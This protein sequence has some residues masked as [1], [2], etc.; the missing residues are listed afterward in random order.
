M[1]ILIVDDNE[2]YRKLLTAIFVDKGWEAIDAPEGSKG[3]EL[4]REHFPDVILSDIMMPHM[5]GF[6]FLRAVRTSAF[7]DILFIFYTSTYTK[8]NHQEFALSLGADAY[9]TKPLN[10]EDIVHVLMDI[11]DGKELRPKQRDLPN[12][13]EFLRLHSLFI[14]EKLMEKA[15]ELEKESVEHRKAEKELLQL[16]ERDR[17]RQSFVT[18]GKTTVSPLAP[19]NVLSSLDIADDIYLP[20]NRIDTYCELLTRD[21]T[22]SGSE[23]AALV[24]QMCASTRKLRNLVGEMG[25]NLY[26]P[27]S[28]V[29]APIRRIQIMIDVLKKDHGNLDSSIGAVL[30]EVEL[31]LRQFAG[32][33]EDLL[34]LG[35][36]AKQSL[37]HE[38]VDLTLHAGE[39][40]SRLRQ[41]SPHRRAEISIEEGMKVKGDAML[42]KLALEQLLDNAWK[43]SVEREVTRIEFLR[44]GQ[45]TGKSLFFIRDNG[46]GFPPGHAE[47]L[48][49]AFAKANDY[50]GN[51]IGL[52]I[53]RWVI[54]RHGGDIWGV[55]EPEHGAIFYFKL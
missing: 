35:N 29:L 5:D 25:K 47:T 32:Y 52:A 6:Q 10:P 33:I 2:D 40:L 11:L 42:L 23:S 16:R 39:I 7:R 26:L 55:G 13:E 45:D 48:F 49:K 50:P 8:E 36:V 27:R 24:E 15:A 46:I 38:Q 22:I 1:K 54:R 34:K 21:S 53:A 12:E 51:G 9:I 44:K 3:L 30:V 18:E 17:L 28:A 4:M 41:L 37:M 43:F 20:L 14:S 31:L 19:Q